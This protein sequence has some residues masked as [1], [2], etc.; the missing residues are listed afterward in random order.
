MNKLSLILLCTAVWIGCIAPAS[1][2]MVIPADGALVRTEGGPLPDGGWNLWTNGRVGQPIRI[3]DGATYQVVVRAFGSPAAGVWPRMAFQMDGRTVRTV[4]VDRATWTDYRFQVELPAGVCE[5]AVAFVNDAVVGDEDRNLYLDRFTVKPPLGAADPI[6]VGTEEWSQ[7]AE[8]RERELVAATDRAIEKHRKADVTLRLVDPQGK[9]VTGAR[10]SVE[11]TRHEFLFGCNI[12]DFDRLPDATLNTAYKKRFEE[13]FNC[14]T[15]GF[16]WRWYERQRGKPLYEYTDKVIAW[17]RYYGIRVKGHPLLWG[18]EAGVPHWSD[19]QPTRDVQRNRV[20]EILRRF[21]G[22]IEFWEVVNEPSHL[23]DPKVDEPYRWARQADPTAHLIINDYAV[24]ADGCPDFF[25][26]VS[27]AKRNGVP[28]DGIGIQAHEPRTMRF[29]LHRVQQILDE[30]AT[31]GKDLH[32]TEFTPTSAGQK[33]TG[34][35]RSGVWDEAAQA[36]YAMKFYRVCFAHPAVVAITWWDLSDAASWLPGGGM[37]RPDMSPKPVYEGLR[38]MIREEWKTKRTGTTD[39]TGLFSF[40]GFYGTYRIA[41]AGL[42][43]ADP[44]IEKDLQI[45][46]RGPAKV[47]IVLP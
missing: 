24:L 34:S 28:F 10:V 47:D 11:Q 32:I 8:Q 3:T 30:Y 15:V 26:L 4:T 42:T 29:P 36:E 6:R 41:V 18:C 12:F 14:A 20:Q 2:D 17:C 25:Q 16:Y 33:I 37:L 19:G 5:L 22:R 31:L 27:E 44:R 1:A 9:P 13:L 23:D 45:L 40:R 7:A 35:H 43:G 39:G 38:R 46:R 21:Q